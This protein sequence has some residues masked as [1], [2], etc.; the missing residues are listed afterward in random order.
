MNFD[1]FQ[2]GES[3]TQMIK[4]ASWFPFKS[5]KLKFNATSGMMISYDTYRIHFN[6]EIAPYIE[7]LEEGTGPHD[8]PHAFGYGSIY[9][10]RPN[11]YTHQIPFGVGGRFDGKFHPGSQ[12]HV[13][14]IKNK[15]VGSI[16]N[17]IATKYGGQIEIV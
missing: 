14:F 11:P 9:E 8:I 7:Y 1:L 16:V 13:G 10:D 3:I 4:N 2:E 12:K 5:G 6:T 17:Y 15:A